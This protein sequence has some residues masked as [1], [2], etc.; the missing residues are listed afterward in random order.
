MLV[1][2][3]ENIKPVYLEEAS[4]IFNDIS[5][6]IREDIC[7]MSFSMFKFKLKNYLFDKTIAKI[8]SCSQLDRQDNDS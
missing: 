2:Q 7:L 3:N 4:K 1:H 8:P 5:N 6:E